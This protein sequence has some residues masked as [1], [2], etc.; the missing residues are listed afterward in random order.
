[1]LYNAI[2]VNNFKK[3]G[4]TVL[5]P[6]QL[7]GSNLKYWEDGIS[8]IDKTIVGTMTKRVT[9]FTDRS[10]N[11]TLIQ[12]NL[13]STAN[14]DIIA[15]GKAHYIRSQC[16]YEQVSTSYF[17]FL[18]DGT[19]FTV[20]GRVNYYK[21]A[22]GKR[23]TFFSNNNGTTTLRGITVAFR[24]DSTNSMKLECAIT[25]GTSGQ[26]VLLA[27]FNNVVPA[28]NQFFDFIF[29]YDGTTCRLYVNGSLV[30]TQA[31]TANLH[32]T[33]NASN[34]MVFNSNPARGSM[35]EAELRKHL[36]ILNIAANTTQRDALRAFFAL[37]NED[38]TRTD[39]VGATKT[40]PF[41]LYTLNGQSNIAGEFD[42]PVSS[43]LVG[44]LSSYT[45]QSRSN[46]AQYS[47]IEK[48]EYDVNNLSGGEGVAVMKVNPALRFS[49][50][51]ADVT[52]ENILIITKAN[53]GT[54]L[55]QRASV[56]DW[57][58]AST[59]EFLDV[60]INYI[61][62]AMDDLAYAPYMASYKVE[63]RGHIWGQGESEAANGN[64][65]TGP[66]VWDTDCANYLHRLF[67]TLYTT[68]NID[69]SKVR[70][71]IMK[72]HNRF[73]PVRPY[74]EDVRTQQD[75]IVNNY[76]TSFYPADTNKIK[77]FNLN[78]TDTYALA[79]DFTHFST[80]TGLDSFGTDLA[81]Y[82]KDYINE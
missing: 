79:S 57:N 59:G 65:G 68:Y 48:L 4:P 49:K 44:P 80:T 43:D 81:N 30:G 16:I 82:Y 77:A 31:K 15:N 76:F 52:G 23:Y 50:T 69:T 7:F 17:N 66:P 37:G 14:N 75:N 2:H 46:S 40:G 12:P 29:T 67:D 13:G 33:A 9:G 35:V 72:I 74:T 5:N 34:N 10:G 61:V 38:F 8:L 55:Y 53:G 58:A 60:T 19:P 21:S 63:Y 39:F 64:N 25:N 26:T 27:S 20:A 3:S 42:G 22:A 71:T 41:K 73:N 11:V 18:H 56:D 78:T 51:L 54:T 1:M 36:V 62:M 24:N 32:S 47:S 6:I 70:V 28:Y 45:W